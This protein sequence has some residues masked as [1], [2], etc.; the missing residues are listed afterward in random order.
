[1]RLI[2]DVVGLL[3]WVPVLVEGRPRLRGHDT[4]LGY[5]TQSIKSENREQVEEN[6]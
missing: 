6:S 4:F 3:T 5:M 2:Q 1:M